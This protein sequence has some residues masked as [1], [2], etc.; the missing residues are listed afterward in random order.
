MLTHDPCGGIATG[1][2]EIPYKPGDGIDNWAALSTGSPSARDE[3]IHV[4]QAPYSLQPP[5]V[6]FVVTQAEGSVL[7]AHAIRSGNMKLLW[8]PAGTGDAEFYHC[9]QLCST[10]PSRSL[11]RVL[12][13]SLTPSILASHARLL[14]E[15]PW[16]VSAPGPGMELHGPIHDSLSRAA[17]TT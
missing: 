2:G 10:V 15:S 5:H 8:H 13:P 7:E 17:D 1:R 3:I 4:V 12:F 6:T 9:D 11:S 14:G 16:V